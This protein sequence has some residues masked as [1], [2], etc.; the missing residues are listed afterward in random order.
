MDQK[1]AAAGDL[2]RGV[3]DPAGYRGT[4][5]AA[6]YGVRYRR[7]YTR[8][9]YAA[10]W[11]DV[12][13]PLLI[14]VVRACGGGPTKLCLDFACGTGRISEAIATEYG[15]VVGVDVSSAMLAEA[16]VPSNVELIE[17]D[18]TRTSLRQQFD[19]ATAFRFFLNAEEPLRRA[20]LRSI[21]SHLKPGAPLIC[22]I[23]MAATSPMGVVYQG[24]RALQGRVV[25]HVLTPDAFTPLLEA[26]GF[27]VERLIHYGYL[28]RP[29]HFLPRLC[30]RLVAPVERACRSLHVPGRWAQSFLV[31]ATKVEAASHASP[32]K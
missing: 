25:H 12:E 18:L 24:A 8:G 15:K 7:T 23:H 19:A 21:Y 26:C 32:Q 14:N 16:R 11:R 20:A 31:V 17:A 6:G 2:C 5:T 3:N 13:R 1:A 29:G 9:Y 27:R 4:H 22:N 30:E 28:P 10:L